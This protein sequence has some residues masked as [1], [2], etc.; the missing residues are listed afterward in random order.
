MTSIFKP[1]KELTNTQIQDI[2][3]QYQIFKKVQQYTNVPWWMLASVWVR[4]TGKVVYTSNSGGPFQFDPPPA[5]GRR[6]S[7]LSKYTTLDSTQIEHYS[8][9]SVFDFEAAAFLAACVL[10][11]KVTGKLT[12][13]ASDELVKDAFWGY[14]GRY[15]GSAEQS[16]YVMNGYD[17]SYLG[18]K[19]KG[20]ID[21]KPVNIVDKNPGAY[22]MFCQLRQLFPMTVEQPQPV[23][24]KNLMARM[25]D[26]VKELGGTL[27]DLKKEIEKNYGPSVNT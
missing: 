1:A 23:V 10:Q 19:V 20:T 18:M 15:Y 26:H 24:I 13:N 2:K 5:E 27:T 4:E 22:V 12:I 14:N 25:E 11:D 9:S 17:D 3:G 21:G 6:R 7:L 16:P 8:K